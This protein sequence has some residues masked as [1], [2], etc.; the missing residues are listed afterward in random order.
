MISLG[1]RGGE[2]EEQSKN[3]VS[4]EGFLFIYL[5][6]ALFERNKEYIK[7]SIKPLTRGDV[8]LLTQEL[9]LLPNV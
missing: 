1:A 5:I 3:D 6:I 8:R 4:F 9:D 2:I 7:L